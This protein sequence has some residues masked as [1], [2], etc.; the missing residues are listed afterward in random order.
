MMKKKLFVA[1]ALTL[2]LATTS[3]TAFAAT[4]YNTPAEAAADI[5]GKTVEEVTQQRQSGTTYGAIAAEAGKLEEFKQAMQDIYKNALAERVSSGAMTQEQADAL[6]AARAERQST[7][8]GSA[9]GNGGCGLGLGG[10]RGMGCGKGSGR[11]MGNGN[12]V[13]Q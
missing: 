9:S 5:T 7:C 13:N 6:L 12:C 8:D 1:C 11:G 2:A 3:L 10:G 4:S